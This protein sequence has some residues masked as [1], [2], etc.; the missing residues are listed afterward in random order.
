[1]CSIIRMSAWNVTYR[2]SLMKAYNITNNVLKK[3]NMGGIST[4]ND[5]ELIYMG[6]SSSH[7]PDDVFSISDNLRIIHKFRVVGGVDTLPSNDEFVKGD[8]IEY[9]E[10]R[11]SPAIS[12]SAAPVSSSSGGASRRRNAKRHGKNRRTRHKTCHKTC[13]KTRRS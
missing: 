5:F 2:T 10:L 7:P 3:K 6:P 12:S 13:R 1:M 8:A 11:P 9:I 4:V